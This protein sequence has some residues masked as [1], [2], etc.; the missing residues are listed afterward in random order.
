MELK[1]LSCLCGSERGQ[2]ICRW[3]GTFLSCLCGSEPL[4]TLRSPEGDFLSC[5]CGSELE[6]NH[7]KLNP[8]VTKPRISSARP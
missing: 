5:L 2:G 4:Q 8:H 7:Q 6:K 1:F 3:F